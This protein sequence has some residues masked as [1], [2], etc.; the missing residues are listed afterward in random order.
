[1]VEGYPI[2]EM[3]GKPYCW[4]CFFAKLCKW[5]EKVAE[6]EYE[7]MRRAFPDKFPKAGER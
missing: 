1:M 4:E 6:E 2:L 7:E 5:R 3:E